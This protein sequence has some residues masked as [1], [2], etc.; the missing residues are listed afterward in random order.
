MYTTDY[1]A[2]FRYRTH[3]TT[4]RATKKSAGTPQPHGRDAVV[5]AVLSSAAELFA[6][7]GPNATS[8]REVAAHSGVNHGLV[9]RHFGTKEK[10]V[11]ATLDHLAA[12]MSAA[13]E[14]GV[15]SAEFEVIVDLQSRVLARTILD[16]LAAGKLQTA[17]P[18]FE[19][20]LE[21]CRRLHPDDR[22]A[23]LAA[24]N[25][26]GLR[27]SWRL[28]GPYLTNMAGLGDVPEDEL[29]ESIRNATDTVMGR[30]PRRR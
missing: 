11:G 23:R 8:I 26:V 3:V 27:W 22:D 21:E 29:Q 24:A 18:G 20:L 19:M 5:A 13:I 16:G 9:F 28:F 7:R 17:F 1:T 10:L 4:H 25:A 6:Q 12:E 15:D 14:S 30:P 2:C